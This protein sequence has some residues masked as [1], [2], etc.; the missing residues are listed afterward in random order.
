MRKLI[1]LLMALPLLMTSCGNEDMAV[2]EETVEVSFCA[3]L[4]QE[5][6]ARATETLSVDKVWCAVFENGV[7]I[8]ALREVIDIA[9]GEQ[10]IF[11][12][13]LIRDRTYDIVFWASKEGSYNVEDM[14]SITRVSGTSATEADFDAFTAKT[15][16]TVMDNYAEDIILAR[17][18]A[19]LNIGVTEADWDGVANQN[20]FGLIPTSI[21]I[22][23][24]GKD[25]F[26]A[27]QGVAIG[28][29]ESLTYNLEVSGAEFVCKDETYKSLAM[30]YVLAESE[31]QNADITYSV[32]DQ[33]G[34]AI[35]E[36]VTINHVPL[37]RNYK[38]NL[39]GG[40]LTG[41]ISYSIFFD[42]ELLTDD[43]HNME[44]E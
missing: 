2:S 35:R 44:I 26:D 21:K 38:T 22:T 12:P 17:P 10:I 4:P 8:A 37:Q 32:Y 1:Y 13:R 11:S 19:Q 41:T 14:T 42:N 24:E 15:S 23:L 3:K 30:C 7:E 5:M 18:I 27:L 28:D 29:D 9:E 20:T 43:E 25:T 31:K 16:I 33:N 36:D 39:V 34:N 6:G 40:L